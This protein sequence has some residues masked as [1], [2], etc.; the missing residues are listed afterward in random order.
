MNY[1]TLLIFPARDEGSLSTRIIKYE[2][3]WIFTLSFTFL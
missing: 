2:S 1:D 3:D